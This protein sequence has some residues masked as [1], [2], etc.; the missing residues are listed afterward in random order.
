TGNCV[1]GYCCDT[2]CSGPCDVCNATSKGGICSNVAAGTI[3]A[4]CDPYLCSGA[5]GSCPTTCTSDAGCAAGFYCDGVACVAKKTNGQSCTG[6]NQCSSGFC[7]DGVC[8]DGACTG[9][10]QACTAALKQSGT[11][12]G[13][14]DSAKA[15]GDPHDDCTD[16]GAAS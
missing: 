10:C 15:G 1:D 14:C 12:D 2:A 7:A 9:K 5:S 8:C 13:T 11:N 16:E 4:A 3:A 6:V